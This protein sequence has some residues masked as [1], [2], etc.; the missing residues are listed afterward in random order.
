MSDRLARIVGLAIGL[1]LSLSACR[2][3]DTPPPREATSESPASAP[4]T[5]RVVGPLTPADAAA[6]A[7]M[8]DRLRD[9]V[10]LHLNLERKLPAVPEAATPE[11]IDQN[12]RMFERLVREARRSAKPGDI[13]TPAARPVIKRLL[14]DVF[15][16]PDGKLLRASI[17]DENPV[18][19]SDIKLSVNDRYPDSIP[20]STV[21]PQVLQTLPKLIEDLEYRF[22]GTWLILLDVHAHVVVDFIEDAM[23]G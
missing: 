21:P 17:L 14:S 2:G 20:L 9:Y 13:F 19:A 10:E 7:T 22:I 1:T 3:A 23:P 11:Q 16:G 18:T 4:A 15:G 8:N 5:E 12:Q 6:L